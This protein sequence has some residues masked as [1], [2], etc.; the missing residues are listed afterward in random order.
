MDFWQT[1]KLTELCGVLEH[2]DH[3]RLRNQLAILSETVAAAV[4]TYGDSQQNVIE[5]H[6]LFFELRGKLW[7]HMFREEHGLYSSIG[8][9]ERNWVDPYCASSVIIGV[10]RGVRRE[11]RHFRKSFRQIAELLSNYE[12]SGNSGQRYVNLIHGFR[13][14]ESLKLKHM[15]KEEIVYRRALALER[16]LRCK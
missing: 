9:I 14:L 4:A 3:V 7:T 1:T 6:Q 8:N 15:Q 5:I 11:H 2:Q 16:E 12:I 13:N 10:I